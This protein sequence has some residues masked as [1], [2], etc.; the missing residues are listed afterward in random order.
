VTDDNAHKVLDIFSYFESKPGDVLGSNNFVAV[1]TRRRWRMADLQ[2]GLEEAH[3][4]G[5]IATAER[6]WR[7]TEN[8]F[9]ESSKAS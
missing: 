5:W 2:E 4:I 8:G 3:R 6:G 1:G 9:R 7:L